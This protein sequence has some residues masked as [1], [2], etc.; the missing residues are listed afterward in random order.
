MLRDI[1]LLIA[2]AAMLFTLLFELLKW[3]ALFYGDS[4]IHSRGRLAII[5]HSLYV[6]DKK[7]K[8]EKR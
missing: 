7:K 1:C 2:C 5:K 6:S 8:G 3:S 4:V